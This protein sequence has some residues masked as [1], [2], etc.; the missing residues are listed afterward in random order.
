VARARTVLSLRLAKL[1]R[2]QTVRLSLFAAASPTDGDVLLQPEVSYKLTDSLTATLGANVFGGSR[3]V[4][5]AAFKPASNA[6]AT[7][8]FDF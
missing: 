8:R 5:F 6:Y 2:Y 7:A 4:G 3:P 1:L